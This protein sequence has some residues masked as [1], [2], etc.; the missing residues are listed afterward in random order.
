MRGNV[1]EGLGE[2]IEL[3]S[4]RNLNELSKAYKEW[5][6]ELREEIVGLGARLE[7]ESAEQLRLRADRLGEMSPGMRVLTEM[8][9]LV[10]ELIAGTV[11]VSLE[12]IAEA[13]RLLATRNRVI[14]EGAGAASVAGA[15]SGRASGGKIVCVVSGGNIDTDRLARILAGEQP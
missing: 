2:T 8:W 7:K 10:R 6:E 4:A 13:I 15:V 12:E 1:E 9:P 3:Y 11:V 5:I 14:A